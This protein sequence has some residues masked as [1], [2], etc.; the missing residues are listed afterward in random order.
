EITWTRSVPSF[1]SSLMLVTPANGPAPAPANVS[2]ALPLSVKLP[3]P[4]PVTLMSWLLLV[5]TV[6]SLAAKSAG[7]RRGQRPGRDDPALQH[8]DAGNETPR[9]P[10]THIGPRRNITSFPQPRQTTPEMAHEMPLRVLLLKWGYV[11]YRL[12]K[13]L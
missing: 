2:P 5:R 3:G 11:S 12:E 9:Q 10:R 1:M 7:K 6:R 4:V 13:R 8:V